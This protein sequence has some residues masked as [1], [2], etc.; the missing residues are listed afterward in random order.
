MFVGCA[1][2]K[3]RFFMIRYDRLFTLI[4]SRNMSVY[5]VTTKAK[6]LSSSTLQSIRSGKG[7]LDCNTLNRLCKYF[8]CQPSDLIE[9]VPDDDENVKAS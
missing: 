2:I 1:Q 5:A 3:E 6:I 7:N 9:Y 8:K 4:E